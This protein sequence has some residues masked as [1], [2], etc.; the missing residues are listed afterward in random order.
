MLQKVK[1]HYHSNICMNIESN[2]D[3][4]YVNLNLF[5]THLYGI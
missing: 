3:Y 4:R 2:L 5:L 1:N